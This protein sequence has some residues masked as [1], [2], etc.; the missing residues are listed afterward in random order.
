MRGMHVPPQPVLHQSN[1]VEVRGSRA[2][3]GDMHEPPVNYIKPVNH[4]HAPP[5]EVKGECQRGGAET[6]SRP[7]HQAAAGGHMR[8]MGC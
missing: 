2:T 5:Y 8:G 1:Q 6:C 7:A 4:L 3:M